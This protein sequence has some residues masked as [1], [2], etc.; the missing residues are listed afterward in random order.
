MNRW[1]SLKA[2]LLAATVLSL[3][4]TAGAMSAQQINKGFASCIQWCTDHNKTIESLDK[5][6]RQCVHIG[7]KW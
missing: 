5:C 7:T 1:G 6:D 2:W 3:P 4:T